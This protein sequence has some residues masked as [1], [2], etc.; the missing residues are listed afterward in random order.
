[1]ASVRTPRARAQ[2]LG[3]AKSGTSD[4][5]LQHVTSIFGLPLALSLILIIAATSGLSYG[6][7]SAYLRQP[8]VALLLLL[9]LLNFCVH[10]HLGMKSI[11]ED[12]VHG[13]MTK[14]L[15]LMANT[16]FTAAIA[17]AA[18]LASLTILI[19]G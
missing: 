16:G 3:S 7:V 15:L 18:G 13:S 19:R 9:A 10:M 11:I 4:F 6:A 8:A 14:P 5:W 17:T 1:M 12:Y 2:G